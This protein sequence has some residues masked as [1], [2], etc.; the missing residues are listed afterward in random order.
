MDEYSLQ[1]RTKIVGGSAATN[2]QTV[3]E[4]AQIV[5]E[6]LVQKYEEQFEKCLISCQELSQ[7]M[8]QIWRNLLIW[9]PS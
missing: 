6:F 8:W 9:K 1:A 7:L 4:I 5:L 2:K 3:G